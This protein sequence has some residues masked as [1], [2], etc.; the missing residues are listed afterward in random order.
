M[1]SSQSIR[2][3]L[4]CGLIFA[5]AAAFRQDGSGTSGPGSAYA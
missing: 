1:I 5:T 3:A 2:I 4:L